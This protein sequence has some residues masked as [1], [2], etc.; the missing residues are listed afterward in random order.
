[1]PKEEIRR[2]SQEEELARTLQAIKPRQVMME[3]HRGAPGQPLKVET[4]QGK[5]VA[6]PVDGGKPLAKPAL[7][8]R[9]SLVTQN[10]ARI[11]AQI[12]VLQEAKTQIEAKLEGM[13]KI[14][15]EIEE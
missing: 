13:K 7:T 2:P 11:N 14:H 9:L 1:M 5:K 3:V 6:V 4:R 10:L 12:E 8:M 15:A